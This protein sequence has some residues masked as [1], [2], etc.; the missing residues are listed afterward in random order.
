MKDLCQDFHYLPFRDAT[1]SAQILPI[2]IGC[3]FT[4][5]WIV[6]KEVYSFSYLGQNHENDQQ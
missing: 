4:S 5:W 1:K 2:V 3:P 6:D